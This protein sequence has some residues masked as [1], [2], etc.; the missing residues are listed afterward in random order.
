M[1]LSS[2]KNLVKDSNILFLPLTIE[3]DLF[4]L[5][6]DHANF[7][8]FKENYSNSLT[9]TYDICFNNWTGNIEEYKTNDFKNWYKQIVSAI[10]DKKL[11]FQ[12]WCDKNSYEV[13]NFIN[14]FKEK[15]NELAEKQDIDQLPNM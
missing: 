4:S 2:K 14:K 1:C 13:A 3:K 11:L 6:K 7:I 5:L 10:G 12:F 8:D 9:L 15:F